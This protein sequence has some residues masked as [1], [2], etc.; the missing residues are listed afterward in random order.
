ME[1]GTTKVLYRLEVRGEDR[2][3]HKVEEDTRPLSKVLPKS[4]KGLPKG[5]CYSVSPI[6]ENGVPIRDKAKVIRYREYLNEQAG[7]PEGVF[8]LAVRDTAALVV[9][10]G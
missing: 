9:V 6:D 2:K 4:F 5:M 7:Y 1:D 10:A 8:F 3:Y